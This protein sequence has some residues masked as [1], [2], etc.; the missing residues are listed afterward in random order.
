M[1]AATR[2]R[3]EVA[4]FARRMRSERGWS[5]KT[6]PGCRNAIDF[7]LDRLD[8]C[9]ITLDSVCIDDIDGQTA[10]WQACGLGRRT[11]RFCVQR[12]RTF[13]RFAEDR[14][15][16]MAGLADGIMAPQFHSG[17]TVPKGLDRDEIVRLPATTEGDRAA[18]I[19]DRAILM[20]LIIYG[21]RAGEV[22]G[23]RL[24]VLDWVEERLQVRRP[25]P[26]RTH[27][28]PLL[29]GLGQTI[30]R[31]LR[32]V[33]PKRPEREP[34]PTLNAPVRP[35]AGKTVG[36]IVGRPRLSRRDCLQRR[37]SHALRHGTARHGIFSTAACR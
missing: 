21:L 28:H 2:A 18:D 31:C 17:E 13:L 12:L 4:I 34:F 36:D 26:G 23:L 24:D 16:C 7:F 1:P 35:T 10:H 20:L 9:G 19:R 14:G 22:A 30:L 5:G 6:V 11:I 25:K 33:R 27:R 29:R 32:E 15:W 3:D 37:G 8:G